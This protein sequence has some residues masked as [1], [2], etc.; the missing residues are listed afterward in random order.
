MELVFGAV[1]DLWFYV[2]PH[3]HICSVFNKK[4]VRDYTVDCA[5]I[6]KNASS[7]FYDHHAIN[8][9]SS[10]TKDKISTTPEYAASAGA[11]ECEEK[12]K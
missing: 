8:K 1:T 9:T 11:R 12:V 7:G 10:N 2:S 6:N 5:S 3:Q 4:E